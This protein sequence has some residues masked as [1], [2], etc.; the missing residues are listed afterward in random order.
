MRPSMTAVLAAIRS[1]LRARAE[2]EMEILALRHQLA[3]LQLATPRRVRL[4]GADGI[5][6]VL[7]SRAWRG[8]RSAVQ[9]VATGYRRR[10]AS[11][12]IRLAVAMAIGAV[13]RRS[14]SHRRRCPSPDPK[15]ASRQSVVG[16]LC[17][18]N[19]LRVA[20]RDVRFRL[21]QANE[22]SGGSRELH[23]RMTQRLPTSKHHPVWA[24]PESNRSSFGERGRAWRT[25]SISFDGSRPRR[26]RARCETC[27]CAAAKRMLCETAAPRRRLMRGRPIN[28]GPRSGHVPPA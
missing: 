12:P 9:I 6:W 2:L 11:S 26:V 17:L 8:R 22:E 14:P 28:H 10:V 27:A 24:A 23:T 1:S 20:V 15:D 25:A 16:R 4:S 3:V 19:T 21:Q 18:A 5:F 13:A 7:L